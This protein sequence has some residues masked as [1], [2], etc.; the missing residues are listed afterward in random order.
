M[1]ILTT[2]DTQNHYEQITGGKLKNIEGFGMDLLEGN[3]ELQKRR[4]QKFDHIFKSD[5]DT[6]VGVIQKKSSI[7]ENT[8]A[9]FQNLTIDY[10][11]KILPNLRIFLQQNLAKKS[12]KVANCSCANFYQYSL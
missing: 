5:K 6:F 3:R 8:I 1:E 7:L 9:Y 4:K 10:S 11:V 2:E 12:C